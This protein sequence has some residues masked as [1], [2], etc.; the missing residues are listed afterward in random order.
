MK[1]LISS[2]LF[3]T[4]VLSHAVGQG[5]LGIYSENIS[6]AKAAALGADN[7]YGD[8]VSRVLPHSPAAKAGLQYLDYIIGID[9]YQ[10]EKGQN[11]TTIL[12]KYKAGD[13]I[14]VH[15]Y[16]KGKKQSL[17]VALGK[18]SE[19]GALIVQEKAFLGIRPHPEN[20][21]DQPGVKINTIENTT[22][23]AI[24]LENGD[25]IMA[26]NGYRMFDWRDI[27]ILIDHLHVGD[28]V[29]VESV[30]NGMP[31]RQEGQIMSYNESQK[32]VT[33]I[34]DMPEWNPDAGAVLGIYSNKI[35]NAKAEKLGFKHLNGSYVNRVISNTGAA[36][37]GLQPFDYIYGINEYRTGSDLNLTQILRKFKPG[38]KVTVHFI[39]Q[40]EQ[41]SAQVTL[42]KR[43]D[44]HTI[45]SDNQCDAPMLGVRPISDKSINKGVAVDI[46]NKKSTAAQMGMKNGDV[47]TQINGYPI[48][49]WDDISTA[50]EN[51]RVGETIQVEYLRNGKVE[52]ASSPIKSY[53]ETYSR[54]EIWNWDWSN[55]EIPNDQEAD[56]SIHPS[57]AIVYVAD[58]RPEEIVE[59]RQ[60]FNIT[61]AS[62]NDLSI[63]NLNV[64]P[65]P[66]NSRFML[67]FGLPES[68]ET[69]IR[70]YNAAG[71]MI[72]NYDLG[73][74]SGAFADQINIAQNG[75]GNYFLEIR[76]NDKAVSKKIQLQAR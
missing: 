69:T 61:L 41:R 11:L 66:A 47:I 74:F 18:S 75:A 25:I 26:I 76:Q 57:N 14:V 13:K 59:L 35:D 24:G 16:R 52:N 63:N 44:N 32:F 23:K 54:Q 34:G 12:S 73:S 55:E 48:I 31:M 72:Y 68:G 42:G 40:N 3:L 60:R 20:K 10:T 45:I 6:K 53:C 2:I 65:D 70:V 4:V 27:A 64:S 71:R 21:E 51:M 30:R 17:E 49:D 19:R 62:S 46:V 58:L 9:A 29:V 50:I 56:E 7:P 67:E 1:H 33:A 39:R 37:A 5:F 8:Y 28:Q 22:A 15:F 43:S 36:N 38:D